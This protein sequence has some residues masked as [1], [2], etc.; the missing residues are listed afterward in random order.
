MYS[1]Y[2]NLCVIVLV[3]DCGWEIDSVSYSQVKHDESDL[4]SVARNW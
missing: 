3:T 2:L 4:T 1:V